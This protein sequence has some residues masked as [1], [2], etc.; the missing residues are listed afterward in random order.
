M[1]N[2]WQLRNDTYKGL[3]MLCAPDMHERAFSI[4]SR[5]CQPS[6][7]VLDL[8]AGSGAWL[9][10][11]SDAGFKDLTA[12]DL[13]VHIF[14]FKDFDVRSID[15]NSQF[16][17]KFTE[18]FNV[19]TALEIIEHLW[20]P[21]DFLRQVHAL[22]KEDGYLLVTTPNTS[23]WVGRLHFLL[24][25]EHRWFRQVDYT[26]RRHITPIT[27]LNMRLMLHEI[28]FKLVEH[29][30]AGSYFGPL[31]KLT[32]APVSLAFRLLFGRNTSGDVNIYLASKVRPK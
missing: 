17:G 31:Q 24:R 26:K 11:L 28:G 2:L 3:P 16:A 25:G 21:C 22:L 6:G 7:S 9:A 12:A 30:T 13:N 8:A 32:T 19:V 1:N 5:Y 20:S 15:L 27:D 29:T 14:K 10:R 18:R 23:H 4:L